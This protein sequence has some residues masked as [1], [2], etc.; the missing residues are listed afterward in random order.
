MLEWRNGK[1]I[2]V[3][4]PALALTSGRS[5]VFQ[6]VCF[7]VLCP[8]CPSSSFSSFDIFPSPHSPVTTFRTFARASCRIMF[9]GHFCFLCSPSSPPSF[10]PLLH[11]KD[12]KIY[13]LD[14]GIRGDIGEFP[15][16]INQTKCGGFARGGIRR[17]RVWVAG[18]YGWCRTWGKIPRPSKSTLDTSVLAYSAT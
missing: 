10:L 9:R 3:S 4:C 13:D 17:R 1:H 16:D 2:P 11:V 7:A 14:F 8:L 6:D 5:F 12:L 15:D 18:K